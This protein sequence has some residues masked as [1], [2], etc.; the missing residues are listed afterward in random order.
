MRGENIYNESIRWVR[1]EDIPA[2]PVDSFEELQAAISDKKYLL[3]V[4]SLAA[5]RWIEQFG[6]GSRKLSIK[7][8]SVLLILVAASSLITALWTRDYW[9]FG[10]L[11]IMAAVFYFSDP[12]SRIAKW[13]T[14]GG[15]VSVVVFFNLLL[16]GLVEASTLVAYAGLTFAAVRAA[17]FINNSAFRK[18]L[19][20]DE[21]LFLA[22]YQNGACSLRKGKSGMVYAHGVTVKE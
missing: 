21:A 22:G 6:S 19:I 9:L 12:A 3:G 2:F 7:V 16:N 1:I 8:L 18:A 20:S 4:D 13:V 14:I 15:A 17:A 10:A 11:P 5:A